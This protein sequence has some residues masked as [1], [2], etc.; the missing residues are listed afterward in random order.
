MT[1]ASTRSKTVTLPSGERVPAFGLGTW[2]MGEQRSR[3]REELD[4]IRLAL[5][6]GVTLIDTAEMYGE[7]G[8]EEIVGEAVAGRRDGLFIV[9]KVHPANASRKGVAAACERSLKRLGT[10]RI[11]LYLL[12]WRSRT[13]IAE[14]LEAFAA[15]KQAGKIRHYGVSNFDIEDMAELWQAP[16]GQG[17]AAN[18]LLY[19]LTR[20]GPEWELLPWM[21]ERG[22]PLMAYSPLEQA[23]LVASP[24]LAGFAEANGMTPAQAALRWLLAQ[25]DV[26]VIPKTA[27]PDRLR[28]NLAALDGALTAGQIAELDRLFP[29]PDER[30]PLDML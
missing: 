23:R 27:H 2:R 22:I 15:L 20:R 14:T 1:A 7:G 26:I 17:I 12:H 30:T 6:L 28:E 5:D 29:P 19:N 8:A 3:R 24:A 10:D 21:R 13:P 9:S 4:A 11:D 18:Q 25:D 16:G